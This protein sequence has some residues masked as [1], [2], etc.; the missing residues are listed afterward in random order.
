MRRTNGRN[1]RSQVAD[2]IVT[3]AAIQTGELD[4]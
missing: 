2:Y 3:K 4:Q 1:E